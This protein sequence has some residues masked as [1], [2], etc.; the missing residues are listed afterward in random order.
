MKAS[1]ENKNR[2]E[3][4]AVDLAQFLEECDDGERRGIVKFQSEF[5]YKNY[6]GEKSDSKHSYETFI[7]VT[8]LGITARVA[9]EKI[10]ANVSSLKSGKSL[11]DVE[12]ILFQ[13]SEEKD[14]NYWEKVF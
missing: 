6:F 12:V 9:P 5:Y 10:I 13:M 7:Q 11:S 14:E 8:D 1:E 4:V 3:V 2:R